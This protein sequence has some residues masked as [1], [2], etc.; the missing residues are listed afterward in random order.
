MPR[1]VSHILIGVIYHPP[2]ADNAKM[3]DHLISSLDTT[4]RDHPH[5]GIILLGDFN[6]LPD[7]QL[8][9]YPLRQLVKD[10]TRKAAILDKI[11]SNIG[12]W[13]EV[14]VVLPAITNSDH[15]SVMI[16]PSA[17]PQRPR[18]QTVHFYRRSSDPSR[19]ALLC[20]ALK[21]YDWRPL[22]DLDNC[23][24][25][26]QYF[27]FAVYS[28]LN[29]YLP[30]LKLTKSSTDKPWVTPGFRVL[31]KRRQ[32]AFMAGD[33]ILYNRL[34][35]R[36]QR[37]AAKLRKNYF[38]AKVEE[39]HSCDPHQWWTKTK[40][41][42]N[43]E[44]SNP[45]VNLEYQGSPENLADTINQFFV[46][47]S[48]H[49]PKVDPDILDQLTDDYTS[50]F[51]VEPAEVELRLARINIYKATGPDD[52]PGWFLRDF[53][54]YLSQPLAAIFNSS[55]REGFV[56]PM[57][58]SAEV[59]P[60]P[61]TS[62]PRSIQT[63]LRPISLL[64]TVAKILESIIGQWLLSVL[65]P[66]FDSNQFGCRRERST[67]HAIMAVI[68]AWQS[69]L[70]RGGAVRA[71]FVDFKKAFDTVNHNLLLRKLQNKNIPH[72]L[73]KWFYSYLDQRSQRV[74][75]GTN[76]SSWLQ[77][78]G[79][80]PQ[81]SWL[82][83]LSFLVLI[84]DLNV[85]CLIHKYVDDTTLSELLQDRSQISNMQF[86][87][88]QLLDW[89]YSNDLVVNFS[90]TKEI[91]MGPPS[92]TS[93]IPPLLV[94][95][96]TDTGSIERVET[97]KLLGIHLDANFSWSSHVD[98]IL[99]KATR[100]LYFLK[101]L[102]RAGVP[103]NQLLHFYLAVIRPVLEYACPVWHH[104]L[105]KAQT[106]QIEAIQRRAIRI[107]YNYTHGMPYFSSLFV[108]GISSLA[109][110]RENLSRKFFKSM[111]Q[112]GSC[113]FHLIPPPRTSA[114][115]SRLRFAAKYPRLPHHIN[116]YRSFLSYALSRYQSH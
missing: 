87:F 86:F 114:V 96:S 30:V 108:A 54:P 15:D 74:R 13:F 91:I 53:A 103:S 79:A 31:I 85:D 49:L 70:D 81:G 41:L 51:T 78:N 94:G 76:R 67:T 24:D 80:M 37:L 21:Q 98:N 25:Q 111:L 4:T 14:P 66:T 39:L 28:L 45:L 16:L 95:N 19:K 33:R 26:V 2:K 101:Q 47:V 104:L 97:F 52:L 58:K 36:T 116:K 12:N 11:Y 89:A 110:R 59:V 72:C 63:D 82:G 112:P 1:E 40:R 43:I 6:Q 35:N 105:N 44:D 50:D 84:D 10:P 115:V 20:Y 23:A 90:K 109:H 73:I 100:R 60:V 5:A 32:R 46:S 56:P 17:S 113:L 93:G 106:D 102:R 42:L 83:P 77:L 8:R 48:A 62:R 7:S 34:R 71:L 65:E 38:A 99:S 9:N 57:W 88:Q 69:V 18:R 64:P 92:L 27:Y 68:H 55:I 22:F 29:H 107:I 3:I 61:K 75:I